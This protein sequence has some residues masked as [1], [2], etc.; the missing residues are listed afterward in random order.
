M[1]TRI[2][3]VEDELIVAFD[4]KEILET[5]GYT[6]QTTDTV[7]KAI[8]VIENQEIDLVLIDI[9][10]NKDKDGIDLGEYLIIKDTI[11]F[12]YI[13][14]FSDKVTLDRAKHTRPYGYITKP[15]KPSDLI[16]TVFM[17]LNNFNY[18][19]VD[20]L[21][22]DGDI[23]SIVPFKIKET[24]HYINKQI[25]EKIE[26]HELAALTPWKLHHFIRIFTKY[27]GVTPYQ[28]ILKCKIDKAVALLVETN[29]PIQEIAFDL[30]FKS[31]SNFSSAFKKFVQDTPENFRNKKQAHKLLM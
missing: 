15:F 8:V 6:I 7:E 3:V 24:I 31:Y 28:Y 22:K 5:E 11:P 23:N 19:Q 21:R 13:T 26:L 20:V 18:K 2:L 10:L 1:E 27:L 4:I 30:G 12:I 25:Y 29:Q 17:T 16:A 14:A 9:R